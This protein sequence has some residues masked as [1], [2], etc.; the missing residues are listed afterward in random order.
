MRFTEAGEQFVADSRRALGALEQAEEA[1]TGR[2]ARPEGVLAI[3]APELFGE[4]HVAPL[5][6]ELLDTHPQVGVRALFSNRLVNLIDEGFDVVVRIG[7]LPSSGLTVITVGALRVVLVAS[8]GYLA[9]HRAPRT[10]DDLA[11]H[12]TIGLTIEGQEQ[13]TLATRGA[14]RK[15]VAATERLVVNTNAVKIAAAVAGQ[16]IT[17][18]LA[19]QVEHEVRDGRLRVLLADH[20][21]PRI[22]VQLVYPEGRAASAK[23]REFLRLATPRLRAIPVLQGKGLEEVHRPTR[24]TRARRRAG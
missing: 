13:E 18:A 16:G 6:F 21:P 17:R 3:T 22:P 4:R 14:R 1:V 23:V 15:S 12:R 8:P 7:R 19:Y 11:A 24:S 2:H 9:R 20:E 5:V 10:P